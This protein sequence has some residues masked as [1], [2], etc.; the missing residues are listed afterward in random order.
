MTGTGYVEFNKQVWIALTPA[1][2]ALQW[3]NTVRDHNLGHSNTVFFTTEEAAKKYGK[4]QA[5]MGDAE[6]IE[7]S[8]NITS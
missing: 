1:G 6:M 2:E 5:M 4:P 7:K 8:G 3:D